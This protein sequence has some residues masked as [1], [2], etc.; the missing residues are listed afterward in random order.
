MNFNKRYAAQAASFVGAPCDLAPIFLCLFCFFLPLSCQRSF[1][2]SDCPAQ[3]L[4]VNNSGCL[5]GPRRELH[6]QRN[7][8]ENMYCT[9][10]FC[11]YYI[12]LASNCFFTLFL[13]RIIKFG[14]RIRRVKSEHRCLFIRLSLLFF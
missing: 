14:A 5:L 4:A 6:R 7:I 13:F 8:I 9:F 10:F 1:R 12:I 3:V 11:M 2:N